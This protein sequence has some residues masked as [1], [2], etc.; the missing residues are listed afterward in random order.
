MA[1]EV[2]HIG[3]KSNSTEPW[4]RGL[5]SILP[6]NGVPCEVPKEERAYPEGG[7]LGFITAVIY[8]T[9]LCEGMLEQ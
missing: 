9:S 7:G 6:V 1:P 4:A 3:L 5:R 8:L 2:P